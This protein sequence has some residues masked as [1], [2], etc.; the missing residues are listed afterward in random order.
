MNTGLKVLIGFDRPTTY[1]GKLIAWFTWG[2]YSHSKMM[3][4][5]ADGTRRVFESRIDSGV[6]ARDHD[7]DHRDFHTDWFFVN[8]PHPMDSLAF[9]RKQVGKGYDKP[10]WW[11]FVTRGKE[12][13]KAMG[14]WFCSEF[15]YATCIKGGLY[16]LRVVEPYKVSPSFMSASPLLHG[17][18][19]VVDGHAIAQ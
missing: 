18:F 3:F 13:R 12:G 2:L 9:A 6:I 17:P 10:M 15:S 11:R 1:T 7:P 4:V 19:V 16:L 5:Y 8:I 14:L